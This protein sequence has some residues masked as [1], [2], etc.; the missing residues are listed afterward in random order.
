MISE[1][2]S[3][4]NVRLIIENIATGSVKIH[5]NKTI[6]LW[7]DKENIANLIACEMIKNGLEQTNVHSSEALSQEASVCNV[8]RAS[9][10]RKKYMEVSLVILTKSSLY[11]L[12][13][14]AR[15][16][17]LKVSLVPETSYPPYLFL[18]SWFFSLS[19]FC[20][21][22]KVTPCNRKINT[23]IRVK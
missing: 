3:W 12:A 9:C 5:T 7:I 6:N 13:D 2:M 20:G 21:L 1:K 10:Q 18:K 15:R 14:R 23:A 22:D 19:S 17:K 8:N 16:Y 11:L 4:I